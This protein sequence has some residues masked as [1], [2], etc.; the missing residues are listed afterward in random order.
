MCGEKEAERA[1]GR[2]SGVAGSSHFKRVAAT[3]K[4]YA[5]ACSAVVCAKPRQTRDDLDLLPVDRTLQMREATQR[6]AIGS[7]VGNVILVEM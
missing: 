5:Y 3:R 1:Y 4:S 7:S 6:E 2:V